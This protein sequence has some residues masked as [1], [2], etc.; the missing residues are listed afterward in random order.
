[1]LMCSLS[2]D[3]FSYDINVQFKSAQAELII[4]LPKGCETHAFSQFHFGGEGV[5]SCQ[6]TQIGWRCYSMIYGG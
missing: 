6:G 2:N 1:M 4:E 3:P 5:G